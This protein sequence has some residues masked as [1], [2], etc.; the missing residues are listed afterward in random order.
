MKRSELKKLLKPL[1][2]ECIKEVMLEDGILSGIVSEVATG[3]GRVQ[4]VEA[5][6]RE[7]AA[8]RPPNDEKFAEMRQESA[9]EQKT[10]LNEQKQKLLDAIGRDAYNGIDLFE[11]TSALKSAGP[12]PGAGPSPQGP[13]ANVDPEDSGVDISN[14]FGSV[15]RS[16]QAHMNSTK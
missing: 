11:G 9:R 12:A 16:W 4:I 13:L 2:K 5:G 3:M 8:A 1:I 7:K 14:L 15:G 10:K 6:P